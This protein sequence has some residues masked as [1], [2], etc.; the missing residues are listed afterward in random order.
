MIDV[1][2]QNDNQSFRRM[3]LSVNILRIPTHLSNVPS[4][5]LKLSGDSIDIFII[6]SD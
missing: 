5:R 1:I 3:H 4:S 2:L 6:R